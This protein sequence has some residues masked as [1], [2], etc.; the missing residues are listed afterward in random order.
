MLIGVFYVCCVLCTQCKQFTMFI[1][2]LARLDSRPLYLPA[3][4]FNSHVWRKELISKKCAAA[5]H[6]ALVRFSHAVSV[7]MWPVSRQGI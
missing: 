2:L 3:E 5:R 6:I 7:K 4:I 1:P